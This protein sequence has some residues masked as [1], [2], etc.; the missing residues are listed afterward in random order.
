VEILLIV[1]LL[2]IVL[3]ITSLRWGYDS[4]EKIDSTEWER[5]VTWHVLE[6]NDNSRF[7]KP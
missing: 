6:D 4:T 1:V 7:E 2:F 5:R 3:D